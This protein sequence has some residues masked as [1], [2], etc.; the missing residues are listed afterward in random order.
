MRNESLL[1][2][3]KVTWQDLLANGDVKEHTTSANEIS[4]LRE[5]INRDIKDAKS[6]AISDDRRYAT[7]YNAALQISKM[8]IGVAGFRVAKGA[9][10]HH[11]SF[12]AMKLVIVTDEMSDLLDYFDRCRR[13]RHQID[14]DAAEVVSNTETEEIVETVI[15]YL[16][17]VESWIESEYPD[18]AK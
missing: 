4:G 14:Y 6:T 7:A 12:E 16:E 15:Q 13:K 8:G 18:L 10:A 1:L 5:L 9:S 3:T 2:E 11:E 17:Q